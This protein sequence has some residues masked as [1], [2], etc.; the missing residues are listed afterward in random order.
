MS[1]MVHEFVLI[2][3]APDFD[4]LPL[5]ALYQ[6]GCDDAAPAFANG[7]AYIPFFRDGRTR[8]AAIDSAARDVMAAFQQ[9]G[10]PYRV[11]AVADIEFNPFVD[12][13]RTAIPATSPD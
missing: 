9:A 1:E 11:V 10:L 12:S 7:V 5:D 3:D 6:V 4:A 2:T 8:A 13:A